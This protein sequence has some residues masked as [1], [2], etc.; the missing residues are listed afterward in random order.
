MDAA[1]DNRK[2]YFAAIYKYFSN[3]Y[4]IE[5][6][7][8]KSVSKQLAQQIAASDLDCCS[9]KNRIIGNIQI[10]KHS[11]LHHKTSTITACFKATLA[12]TSCIFAFVYFRENGQ[13]EYVC[14][15][16]TY[17]S[18]DG[19][20]RNRFIPYLQFLAVLDKYSDE[21]NKIESMVTE[22]LSKNDLTFQVD[23]YFPRGKSGGDLHE[24]VN[25][26]RMP[27][28][29]F[30]MCWL[31]DYYQIHHGL[32]ENH[33]NPAYQ[34]IF[35][36]KNDLALFAEIENDLGSRYME[37]L[38][39]ISDVMFDLSR[40]ILQAPEVQVGQKIF[41]LTSL[42]AAK[43]NDITFDTWREI[44]ITS[45][46]SNI[47]LNFI[48]PSFPFINNWFYISSAHA[49]LFD[50]LSMHQKYTHAQI[51]SEVSNQLKRIDEL[52]YVDRK[53]ENGPLSSK[54]LKISRA[55]RKSVIYTDSD[56]KLTDLALCMTSEY[57]GRTF[58][59]LPA[60][61]AADPGCPAAKIFADDALFAKHMFE[62]IYAFYCMNTKTMLIHGDPHLNNVTLFELN[63][64][65]LSPKPTSP[66]I[67][68]ILDDT[69]CFPHIGA[70]SMVIDF[71][72]AIIGAP[73]VIIRD[74]SPQYAEVYF[75]DQQGRI[76][77]I[78]RQYFPGLVTKYES[79]INLLMD[80]NFPLVFKI[81][82]A[83]DAYAVMSNMLTMF[84]VDPAF[85][86][87]VK[88]APGARV[89]LENII[90][91]ASALVPNLI[92]AINGQLTNPE[93]LEWPCLT[94]IKK[95]FS[96]YIYDDAKP[97][98]NFVDILNYN[99]DMKYDVGQYDTWGPMLSLDKEVELRQKYKIPMDSSYEDWFRFKRTNTA[100]LVDEFSEKYRHEEADVLAYEEWMIM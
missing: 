84:D 86:G 51:A 41:A 8:D 53:I 17:R 26:K 39:N 77:Q 12:E 68:Y 13:P 3:Q 40:I 22:K 74:Y 85:A 6:N 100:A 18:Q 99:N 45:L 92:R 91:M 90:D 96:A 64:F 59:D 24:T 47:S 55:I 9:Q 93:E 11:I 71:S 57:V 33:I 83:V 27:I 15:G 52:N 14:T 61:A 78:L 50:N 28:K 65:T 63:N 7:V 46:A 94:M 70:Y 19:E 79:K 30:I 81:I 54:F 10:M 4:R 2:S 82:S 32:M 38:H 48:S 76:L 36:Q 25:N 34:F 72:R 98:V 97:D 62:F 69:F 80:T 89:M 60:I 75:K 37:L 42:E 88:I 66:H 16:P 56:I 20:Y 35:S 73:D 44:Y 67:G 1:E 21:V 23:F 49:G 5:L 29:L 58:R 95:V 43:A 87:P 31:Y